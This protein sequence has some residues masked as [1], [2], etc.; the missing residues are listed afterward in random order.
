V[1]A[2][3][4]AQ[5]NGHFEASGATV[6]GISTQDKSSHQQFREKHGLKYPLVAD[7]DRSVGDVYDVPRGGT[8]DIPTSSRVSFLID[9]QGKIA[10]V[11]NK[12]NPAT[13]HQAGPGGHFQPPVITPS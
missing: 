12:V 2:V 9:P 4:Y 7:T 5:P 11:W 1:S 6:V 8:V 3:Q 10:E 13:Q